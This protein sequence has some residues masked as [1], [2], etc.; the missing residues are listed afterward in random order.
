M[1]SEVKPRGIWALEATFIVFAWVIGGSF[2]VAI[3]PTQTDRTNWQL[4]IIHKRIR[5]VGRSQVGIQ[6][7]FS[8][9]SKE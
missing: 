8:R 4:R 3:G 2:T 7:E 6:E 1:S 5:G 9:A